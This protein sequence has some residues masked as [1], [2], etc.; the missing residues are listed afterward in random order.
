MPTPIVMPKQGNTVESV[1]IVDWKKRVGEHIEAG[2]TLCEVETDKATMEV[3]SPVA[4]VLLKTLYSVGDEVPV[5]TTIAWIGEPGEAI[6]DGEEQAMSSEEAAPQ[7]TASVEAPTGAP[8]PSSS[9]A[10]RSDLRTPISPRARHLA[11]RKG[12]DASALT[13]SGPGGRIIERDVQAAIRAQPKLTPVAKAMVVEGGYA[14]PSQGSGPGGRITSKDLIRAE[15]QERASAPAV[16]ETAPSAATVQAPAAIPRPAPLAP[17]E[18]EIIPVK[19][20]RKV[21]AERMLQSLQTTA[22]L[23]IHASADARVLQALR[24]RFKESPEAMGLRGITINDLVLFAVARTLPAHPALNALFNGTEIHQYRSVHLG[25]AVDTPRGLM[26]PVIR[27]AE[28]LSLR[29]LST[30]AR[31]LAAACLE[32]KITPDELT[33]GTFTVTNLGAFGVESFTP[34]L[35]P[36]QVAILG[37]C[38]IQPKAVEMDGEVQ[39]IPHIGLSL[40][41]NHQV[42]DGA[43]AARFLQALGQAIAAIDLL[44]VG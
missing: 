31:R 23:T 36:P 11:E 37:V 24:R 19:G 40:T 12:V 26:V 39:F 44:L 17:G 15:E 5:M 9:P 8:A 25:V 32:N 27:A 35:N 30:E 20:V 38:T 22:Q 28:T 2:D 33:G 14:V 1:I 41:I 4:G 13:G 6:P 21:I 29:Q 43:P 34:V 7:T 16:R 18:V 3:P 42:V 10:L